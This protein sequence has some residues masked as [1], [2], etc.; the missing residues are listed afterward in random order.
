[1]SG[2]GANEVMKMLNSFVASSQ[3]KQAIQAE[4]DAGNLICRTEA[5]AVEAAVALE[6]ALRSS[7]GSCDLPGSVMSHIDSARHGP[8]VL[9]PDGSGY[10]TISLGGDLSRQ[11]LDPGSYYGIDNI[12][13]LFNNGYSARDYVFGEWHGRET[14]SMIQ[15]PGLHF[16]ETAVDD[17]N[18]SYGTKINATARLIGDY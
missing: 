18:S 2:I 10:I 16:L 13:A 3:G 8:P 1:M 12:V 9:R 15:R 14:A 6:G 4:I 5:D 7:A 11:S 17:F